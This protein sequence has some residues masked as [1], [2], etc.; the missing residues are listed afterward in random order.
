MGKYL[1]GSQGSQR[2]VEP[3]S[4]SSVLFVVSASGFQNAVFKKHLGKDLKSKMILQ[5]I[6]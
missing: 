5:H 3:R 6:I 4:S 1:E 2:A